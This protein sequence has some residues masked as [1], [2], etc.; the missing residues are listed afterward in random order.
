[1]NLTI[2][3][4]YSNYYYVLTAL[5]GFLNV[6]YTAILGGVGNSI[7]VD[8][9]EKQYSLFSELSKILYYVIDIITVCLFCLY[10]SFM[11]FWLGSDE[12]L[13]SNT[14]MILFVACFYF[15]QIRIMGLNFKEAAGLWEKDF[16]KPYL[17]ILIKI[18]M[19]LILVQI[20]GINGILLSTIFIMSIIY[21]PW[22]TKIIFRDIFKIK[23]TEYFK[24]YILNICF[25]IFCC[26]LSKTIISFIPNIGFSSLIIYSMICILLTTILFFII[27]ISVED[28]KNIKLRIYGFKKNG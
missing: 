8:N 26:I 14:T 22:E 17:G 21:F 9:K 1:M 7:V 2:L 28:L 6:G 5:I 23:S 3:S 10:Q 4:I 16:Y 19:S 13:F 11:Y 12:Y 15:W 25:V 18:F 20:I 24:I 27:F